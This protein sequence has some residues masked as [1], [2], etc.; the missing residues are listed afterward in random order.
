MSGMFTQKMVITGNCADG[1]V[2][3]DYKKEKKKK[4]ERE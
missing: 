1:T 2:D 4:T 3:V